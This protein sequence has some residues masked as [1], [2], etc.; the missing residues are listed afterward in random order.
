MLL[1]EAN[2]GT[3][4]TSRRASGGGNDGGCGILD[5]L[6]D[7]L[8]VGPDDGLK[9]DNDVSVDSSLNLGDG[10][11]YNLALVTVFRSFEEFPLTDGIHV[12]LD[13]S[14]EGIDLADND[15]HGSLLLSG[16]KLRNRL[17]LRGRCW[18][19]QGER[20]KGE[21]AEELHCLNW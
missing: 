3:C 17:W 21:E 1:S 15:T 13:S 7:G 2:D 12:G 10:R 11:G 6:D 4:D 5:S 14:L 9:I 8:K 18:D 19:R 16:D 20:C